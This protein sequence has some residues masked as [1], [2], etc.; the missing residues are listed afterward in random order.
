M[1]FLPGKAVR[2]KVPFPAGPVP[3]NLEGIVRTL[4][5]F[6]RLRITCVNRTLVERDGRVKGKGARDPLGSFPVTA[7]MGGREDVR[8]EIPGDG[9]IFYE[10][11]TVWSPSRA[12]AL[13][14]PRAGS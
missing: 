9:C 3:G 6:P 10:P 12:N 13:P 7:V 11:G 1:W 5:I 8:T 14:G 4:G 2:K